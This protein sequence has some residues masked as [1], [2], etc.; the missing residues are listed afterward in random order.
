M[1]LCA[2]AAG[3]ALWQAAIGWRPAES[4]YPT[5]GVMISATDGAVHWPTLKGAGA[6]FAYLLA[7][8]GDEARDP[9]FAINRG[10]A[11]A[12]GLRYGVVHKWR[13]CRLG[14]DQIANFL[15]N[16]PR[17][18]DMLPPAVMLDLEDDC[19][20]RPDVALLIAELTAFLEAIEPYS[21]DPAVLYER[22]FWL[23]RRLFPPDY[24]AVPWA[25]WEASD[26]R[27][28]EGVENP[29]RWSVVR[30]PESAKDNP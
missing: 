28:V 26:I 21:G 24:G 25:I 5:Q 7:T 29:V 30:P 18:P 11:I 1:L 10:G 27:R 20:D 2:A 16:V 4:Q 17:D 13:L 22:S 6:D 8:D 3:F 23:R 9:R 14:A 19:A 15:A 12:A